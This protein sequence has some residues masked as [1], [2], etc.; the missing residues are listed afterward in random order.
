MIVT[1]GRAVNFKLKKLN[2]SSRDWPQQ[3]EF[4]PILV[5][6]L[7]GFVG[8]RDLLIAG[9]G[10]PFLPAGEGAPTTGLKI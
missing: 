4:L 5:V 9:I 10:I 2:G 6:E 1:S 7:A 3:C 8:G